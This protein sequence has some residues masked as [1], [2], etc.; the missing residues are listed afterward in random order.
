M[1]KNKEV[2]IELVES[3]LV[4][5]ELINNTELLGNQV[6]VSK[7]DELVDGQERTKSDMNFGFYILSFQN[8][9][10]KN[11]VKEAHKELDYLKKE[12]E[13]KQ[14]RK[15]IRAKQKRLPKR[16]P[17]TSEIYNELIVFVKGSNYTDVRLRIAFCLL[18]VTGMRVN[19]LLPLK[20]KQLNTLIKFGWIASDRSKNGPRNHK[21]FL[22]K[23]GKNIVRQR[24]KD[25]KFMFLMKSPDC[26]IFTSETVPDKMLTRETIT[27]AVN[28]VT[29]IVSKQLP[30]QPII[31]SHS[32][33]SGY[34]T[35]LWKNCGDIEFV[36]QSIG[37]KK[38]DTTSNYV[39]QLSDEQRQIRI[40]N[41]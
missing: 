2:E 40:D 17:I 15:K 21:A 30:N 39:K 4:E 32:F 29:K 24:T 13:E 36:K 34:I 28:R 27:K 3:E 37:H 35:E 38:L 26:Y 31:T 5:S 12:R 18:T 23:E 33:R 1:N 7:M 19:E 10:L 6:L 20:I 41:I 22:T 9:G 8:H 16:D 11:D 25:F 14:N